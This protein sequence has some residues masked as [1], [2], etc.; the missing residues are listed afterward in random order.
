MNILQG[1]FISMIVS[2]SMVQAALPQQEQKDFSVR[3]HTWKVIEIMRDGTIVAQSLQDKNLKGFFTPEFLKHNE[4]K[5]QQF[6][7]FTKVEK[8]EVN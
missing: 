7:R 5:K 2:S 4:D 6:D 3:G 8:E 1:F